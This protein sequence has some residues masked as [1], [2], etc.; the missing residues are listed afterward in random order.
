MPAS[1]LFCLATAAA[2]RTGIVD[3]EFAR[4]TLHKVH[5]TVS[6]LPR[7]HGLLPHFI[8]KYG[9]HYQIHAG[10]EYSTADT[11]L[12]YHGMLLA[13]QMLADRE[14]LASLTEA[15]K[16]I[17]FNEL[18]DGDGWITHGI[19]DDR[20]S[21]LKPT[22]CDWGG[23]TALVLLLER[24]ASGKAAGM[25]MDKSGKVFRGVGFI[26]E[27]QSLFYPQFSQDLPDAVS[28]V[29]WLQ[30]R[31]DLLKEQMGYFPRTRPASAAAKLGLYGLSSGE[32][33]HGVGYDASG[34]ETAGARL[35]HPHYV[36][37]SAAL[38]PP[39]DISSTLQTMEAR[40]LLPPWGMVENFTAELDEYL[41]MLGSLNAAFECLGAYHLWVRAEGGTDEVYSAARGCSLLDEAVQAFYP[42]RP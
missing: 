40:G 21:R 7:A 30:A 24:M 3:E 33:L 39:A 18:R 20:Q 36:L 19:K 9:G 26:A 37:M 25:K 34:T 11:S 32:G 6:S 17:R 10:T 41:P 1:G 16:E 23:E 38:R 15:V 2:W 8:R 28:G 29:N 14:V 4:D 13:A 27:I 42:H 5:Q 35:L 31:R 22:W 12:Y